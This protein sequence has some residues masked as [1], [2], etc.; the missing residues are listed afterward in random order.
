MKYR[1]VNETRL[2]RAYVVIGLLCWING[3]H[4]SHKSEL[5][6][7]VTLNHYWYVGAQYYPNILHSWQFNI[8][9]QI[10]ICIT[11][12]EIYTRYCYGVFSCVLQYQFSV[13]W[14]GLFT[15]INQDCFTGAIKMSLDRKSWITEV[16]NWQLNTTTHTNIRTL[17]IN[18]QSAVFSWIGNVKTKQECLLHQP[19]YF[20]NSGA[21]GDL[22]GT[23]IWSALC[24]QMP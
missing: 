7:A 16:F 2:W 1:T 13:D 5:L 3:L 4:L 8:N 23:R 24:L 20:N 17:C 22:Y 6:K 18:N 19:N 11:S 12:H 9:Q 14:F 10:R 21:R 15:C